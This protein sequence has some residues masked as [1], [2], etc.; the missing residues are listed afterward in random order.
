MAHFEHDAPGHF[1]LFHGFVIPAKAGIHAAFA[2]SREALF[3]RNAPY[4]LLPFLV[5]AENRHGFP[6]S[7]E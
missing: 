4:C 5:E 3:F 7:R 6:L 2:Y 1:S